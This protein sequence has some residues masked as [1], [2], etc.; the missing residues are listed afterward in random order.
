[1]PGPKVSGQGHLDSFVTSTGDL[2]KDLV[3]SLETDLTVVES[4]G[5]HHGSVEAKEIFGRQA[6][7]KVF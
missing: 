6:L 2:E 1:M 4:P 7:G 3:L 5:G